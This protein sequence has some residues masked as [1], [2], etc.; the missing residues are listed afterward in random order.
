M[1]VSS[2]IKTASLVRVQNLWIY[3]MDFKHFLE[4]S[5]CT[6]SNIRFSG[7]SHRPQGSA[8]TD[9]TILGVVIKPSKGL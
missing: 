5:G 2:D 1:A 6:F 4:K 7:M 3:E 8:S 9:K